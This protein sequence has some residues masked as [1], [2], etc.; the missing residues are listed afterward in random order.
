[1]ITVCHVTKRFGATVALDD[2]SVDL[3]GNTVVAVRGLS[4]AGKSTLLHVVAGLKRPDSGRV[5]VGGVDVTALDDDGR[6]RF[7]S[8]RVA[9]VAASVGDGSGSPLPDTCALVVADDATAWLSPGEVEATAALLASLR[10]PD[11]VVLV[12][13]HDPAVAAV[14]DRTIHLDSGNVR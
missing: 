1:M 13:T 4:G 9:V 14:A 12:A 8:E 2:V 7:L 11:R 3:A 5:T 10:A 6:R